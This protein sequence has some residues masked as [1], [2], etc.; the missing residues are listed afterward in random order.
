MF[1]WRQWSCGGTKLSFDGLDL[2]TLAQAA[3]RSHCFDAEAQ[4]LKLLTEL[5]NHWILVWHNTFLLTAQVVRVKYTDFQ[6]RS[7]PQGDVAV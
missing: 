2:A 5:G 7:R 4:V 1:D 3:R 6:S